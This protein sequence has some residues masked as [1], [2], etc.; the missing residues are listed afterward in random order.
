[1]LFRSQV[2]VIILLLGKDARTEAAD[3][4]SHRTWLRIFLW[5]HDI[6]FDGYWYHYWIRLMAYML[7]ILF[8]FLIIIITLRNKCTFNL[9]W[10][11]V[12]SFFS[13]RDMVGA[14]L[15]RSYNILCDFILLHYY[16]LLHTISAHS[17]AFLWVFTFLSTY[18]SCFFL[19]LHT[20][21]FTITLNL[22]VT[23]LL[24]NTVITLL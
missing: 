16:T 9:A 7:L 11:N 6:W 17:A 3:K 20:L 1:M 4:V 15:Y 12:Y 13:L 18:N 19:V 23:I 2:E 5:L 21:F 14:H 10:L 22:A 24:C 8:L